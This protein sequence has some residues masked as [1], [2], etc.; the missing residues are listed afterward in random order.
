[1]SVMIQKVQ[2]KTIDQIRVVEISNTSF[3]SGTLLIMF[4]VGSRDETDKSAGIAH[5]FEHIVF[6]GTAKFPTYL[7][8]SLAAENLGGVINAFTSHEYTGFW[9]KLASEHYHK[10]FDLL[11]DL[12]SQPLVKAPEVDKERGVIIEELKM[13]Q[14][15]PRDKVEDNFMGKLFQDHQLGRPIIGNLK[16]LKNITAAKLKSFH[17]KWYSPENMIVVI[18]G[19][20]W[21]KLEADL[22]QF[23]QALPK[24]HV[25]HK[26]YYDYK[27]PHNQIIKQT[28]DLKQVYLYYGGVGVGLTE[29]KK[30]LALSLL[31]IIIARDFSSRL[32]R[33]IREERGLAYFIY[34]TQEAFTD[35]GVFATCA[36]LRYEA[37]DEAVEIIRQ[38]YEGIRQDRPG[39]EL[40]AEELRLAKIKFKSRLLLSM[41]DSSNRAVFFGKQM[42]LTNHIYQL[43]EIFKL[44][45]SIN[46]TDLNEL[47]K[48]LFHKD[49][50]VLSLLG[51]VK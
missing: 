28:K 36:G 11:T 21:P 37:V 49:K 45:D 50:L 16:S 25:A 27:P 46:L 13:Y 39:F 12:V 41:E 43:S 18:S 34:N 47:A 10:G 3:P 44:V 17:S 29:Y 23:S 4:N 19:D 9:M 7:D 20:K 15:Q 5:F 14:D 32:V 30:L 35:T 38:E 2:L 24:S 33:K 48:E 40:K 26:R 31:N 6:K 8:I 22:P 51:K 42:L 1:M